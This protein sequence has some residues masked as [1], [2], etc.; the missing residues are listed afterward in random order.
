M[1]QRRM[2]W[3]AFRTGERETSLLQES[4]T[5]KMQENGI[6]KQKMIVVLKMWA[7]TYTLRVSKMLFERNFRL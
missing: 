1:C 4:T 3:F 6:N 7:R 2:R 5:K